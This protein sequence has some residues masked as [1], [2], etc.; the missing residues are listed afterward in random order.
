MT[1]SIFTPGVGL[2]LVALL[3]GCGQVE[4]LL[5]PGPSLDLPDVRAGIGVDNADRSVAYSFDDVPL[6]LDAPG[7]V[8]IDSVELSNPT[9]GLVLRR[10][11]VRDSPESGAMSYLQDQRTTLAAAGYPDGPFTVE[12]V[13]FDNREEPSDERLSLL[14]FEVERAADSPDLPAYSTGLVVHYTSEGDERSAFVGFAVLLCPGVI[15]LRPDCDVHE[16]RPPD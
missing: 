7:S 5:D 8:D 16:V 1:A 13:C 11:S 14:G 4:R 9:G 2:L 12:Q 15:S 10:F 6:C 3:T